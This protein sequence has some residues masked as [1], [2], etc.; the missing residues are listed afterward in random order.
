MMLSTDCLLSEVTLNL[1]TTPLN[2]IQ[3]VEVKSIVSIFVTQPWVNI[4]YETGFAPRQS[5]PGDGD[6][7]SCLVDS[8]TP[9]LNPVESDIQRERSTER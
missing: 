9:V 6:E 5:G 8:Q 3:D 7:I 1:S 4:K 2:F